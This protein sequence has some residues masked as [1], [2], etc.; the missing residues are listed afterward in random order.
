LRTVTVNPTES[1]IKPDNTDHVFVIDRPELYKFRA[2]K[3]LHTPPLKQYHV[4]SINQKFVTV[5]PV[6]NNHCPYRRIETVSSG[7]T[8]MLLIVVVCV[9]VL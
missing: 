3:S 8:V 5:H 4:V 7:D 9:P 2:T 6:A 1:P